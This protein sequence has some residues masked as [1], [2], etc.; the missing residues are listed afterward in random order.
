MHAG[1]TIQDYIITTYRS[2][3][4]AAFGS[5]SDIDAF[6]LD[7]REVILPVHGQADPGRRTQRTNVF[8]L[9]HEQSQCQS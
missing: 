8:S 7:K 2:D 1:R 4:D 6:V 9:I 3:A 5:D